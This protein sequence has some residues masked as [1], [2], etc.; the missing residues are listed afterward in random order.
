MQR[1]TICR[2][3]YQGQYKEESTRKDR[4]MSLFVMCKLDEQWMQFFLK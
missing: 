2:I 1:K 3:D 4:N